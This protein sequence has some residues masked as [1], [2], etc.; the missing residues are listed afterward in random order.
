VLALLGA[1]GLAG[2]LAAAPLPVDFWIAL[3]RARSSDLSG[4]FAA[5]FA[6]A[7]GLLPPKDSR[8]RRATGASTVD[9]ADLT[10][11]PC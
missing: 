11:S 1:A 5:G 9:D 7:A 3:S 6:P 2:A 4:A 8:S 10:N